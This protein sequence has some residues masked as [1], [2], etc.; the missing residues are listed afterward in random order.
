MNFWIIVN[1]AAGVATLIT[2]PVG[3]IGTLSLLAVWR[4]SVA[5][6]FIAIAT[7]AMLI[8]FAADISLRA[9]WI[10]PKVTEVHDCVLNNE[11][12]PRDGYSYSHCVFN[13]VTFVI[14]GIGPTELGYIDLHGYAFTSDDPR[15]ERAILVLNGL[16]ALRSPVLDQHG[17]IIPPFGTNPRFNGPPFNPDLGQPQ[18]R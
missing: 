1:N 14:N 8:L 9:G 10:T 2:F 17:H 15:I 16:G 5:R 13:N 18:S 3:V 11:K 7:L 12:V 6:A 4:N